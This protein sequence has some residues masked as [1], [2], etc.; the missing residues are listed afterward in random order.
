MNNILV[1]ICVPIYGVE[2]YIERC[3]ISLFEQSYRNIEYVFVNDCSKDNSM[4]ILQTIIARYPNRAESVRII[5][6]EHN[7]GLAAARNTAVDNSTGE[8]LVHVD[9]DDYM[10]KDAI[11]LLVKEQQKG[12]YDIVFASG[13]RQY[14][15]YSETVAYPNGI[16]SKDMAIKMLQ[17]ELPLYIW[18]KLIRRS[19]YVDNGIHATTG[20]NN[21]ED[22]QVI[23]QL[24]L[25]A[26][27]VSS[28]S[29]ILYF[30]D[31]T[32]PSSYTSHPNE[33][34]KDEERRRASNIRNEEIIKK[35]ND[36][37][38]YSAIQ[39]GEI[40]SIV[41]TKMSVAV[42]RDTDYFLILCSKQ[43]LIE[44]KYWK[45]VPIVNWIPMFTSNIKIVRTYTSFMGSV[46]HKIQAILAKF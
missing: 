5:N 4:A 18:G 33:R 23:P 32:N 45:Y 11:E 21:G 39:V 3:S 22:S 14:L 20:V 30:Y 35:Y 6:H 46:K 13:N 27:K 24:V 15:K 9:S 16:S 44:R 2:K 41:K 42:A 43:R 19:L 17:L 8:F 31:C 38:L 12:D 10:M 1:S 29:N 36:D 40:R 28:I 7:K 25:A 34:K 26:N 37:Q